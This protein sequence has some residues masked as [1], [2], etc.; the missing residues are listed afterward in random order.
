MKT[1]YHEHTHGFCYRRA[2]TT[3][4]VNEIFEPKA[5]AVHGFDDGRGGEFRL[6]MMRMI[7][8]RVK[9]G[10]KVAVSV[11][12]QILGIQGRKHT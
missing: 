11:S 3:K 1:T 10:Y 6:V 9:M 2:E 4:P 5:A 8:Q 12:K 7:G